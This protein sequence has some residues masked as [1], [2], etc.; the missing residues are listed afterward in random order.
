MN[1]R[2]IHAYIRLY[3]ID[4]ALISFLSYSAGGFIAGDYGSADMAIATLISL[5]SFNFI[6]S[7][8]SWSDWKMDKIN[9]P[10]RPIPAGEMK[11]KH[12][13]WYSMILLTLSLVYPFFFTDSIQV[14][15]LFMLLP[16]FGILYSA[17]PI[18]LKRK[19]AFA[20]PIVTLMY[21]IPFILGYILNTGEIS[22]DFIYFSVA[23]FI[24]G[25][26]IIPL[27]DIEDEKGDM[28]FGSQ[29]WS[30]WLGKRR[31]AFL[32][33]GGLLTGLIFS[34]FAG[35][36]SLFLNIFLISFFSGSM[37]IVIFFQIRHKS[38]KRLYRSILFFLVVSG[39]V[40][41]ASMMLKMSESI[42][43]GGAI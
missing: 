36:S 20:V 29:N 7:F 32:S 35:F 39:L 25:L 2:K 8:N 16:I 5:V 28:R 13:F 4:V 33:I 30:S 3:R 9:K 38:I 43:F 24:Y 27:K 14:F 10:K 11:P 42:F 22:S 18:Y 37:A 1:F 31:L 23:L 15:L 21:L 6:Y 34:A 17:R 40:F 41:F 19:A 12:A 26:S